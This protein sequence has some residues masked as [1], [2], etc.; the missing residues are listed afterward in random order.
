MQGFKG[1]I[2]QIDSKT[3]GK[4]Y[5]CS[6]QVYQVLSPP[7]SYLRPPAP[8]RVYAAA[9][10]GSSRRWYVSACLPSNSAV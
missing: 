2:D 5:V 1:S 4:S 3:A 6:G 10:A 8:P 7:P 9:K